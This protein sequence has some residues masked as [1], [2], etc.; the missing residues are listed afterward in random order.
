MY[1]VLNDTQTALG[2]RWDVQDDPTPRG[3]NVRLWQDGIHYPAL[4]V[5][6]APASVSSAISEVK[7]LWARVGFSV[8][9]N[10]IGAVTEVQ[11]RS[12]FNELLIFRVS[13]DGMTLQ[14]ESECRPVG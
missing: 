13:T 12:P 7:A 4:R 9:V 2:G 5:A 8:A 11:A 14:G 10:D 3:C 6:P 1:G